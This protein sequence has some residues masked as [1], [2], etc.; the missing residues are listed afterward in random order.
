MVETTVSL[1]LGGGCDGVGAALLRSF[2]NLS[3]TILRQGQLTGA[4]APRT[5][6]QSA[7]H[8]PDSQLIGQRNT[9][10]EF[11]ESVSIQDVGR[12]EFVASLP[13]EE[14][15][16]DFQWLSLRS[17]N[18]VARL[19]TLEGAL[20][21]EFRDYHDPGRSFFSFSGGDRPG[22]VATT[23]LSRSED[24]DP[25]TRLRLVP[26]SV[27]RALPDS[28]FTCVEDSANHDYVYSTYATTAAAGSNYQRLRRVSN[29]IERKFGDSIQ[30]VDL[31]AVGDYS[32][33]VLAV[34][35][36]WLEE[37]EFSPDA[38]D[39]VAALTR[40]LGILD[41]DE[42]PPGLAVTGLYLEGQL[43]AFSIDEILSDSLAI[44][45]FGH[46]SRSVPDSS[47]FLHRQV[48]KILAQA[49][50]EWL[51]D[52]Q[53]L[54]N[55]GLRRHK[56]LNNPERFVRKYDVQLASPSQSSPRRAQA[57]RRRARH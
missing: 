47:T 31:A 45:H 36:A 2:N 50:V 27:V 48:A 6:R 18:P 11:P 44:G 13:V 7:K 56:I 4:H 16:S 12:T 10:P 23:L 51:N 33:Q 40:C 35:T 17:W 8:H 32:H 38:V 53:D 21:V 1:E 5:E 29:A 14:E 34:A 57:W 24:F 46:A 19:S 37:C 52:E 43:V 28:K 49:G 55:E 41:T 15:A 25:I 26:E 54:G 22:H 9:I 39:E 3:M 42:A 30:V 20:V